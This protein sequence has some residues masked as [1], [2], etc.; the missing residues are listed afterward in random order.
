M[1]RYWVDRDQITENTVQF[2]GETFHHVIDVCRLNLGSKFEVLTE[3]GQAYFVEITEVQKK[4]AQAK[5]L[6]VRQIP[7]PPLPRIH[8]ALSLPRFQKF[9]LIVEKSVEL[10]VNSIQPL[11]SEFSFIR[12]SEKIS[13]SKKQRWE[14]I[15]RSATQQSGRGDLMTLKE[16]Q[17][18]KQWLNDQNQAANTQYL[19]MYEGEGDHSLPEVLRGFKKESLQD[20]W[21]LIGSEGGFSDQEVNL[22]REQ[23]FAPTSVGDQI[24]RVETACI[25]ITS[26]VNYELRL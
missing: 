21:I 11:F 18:L 22:L 26:M 10:G 25:A 23:G 6:E 5:I 17:S 2:L 9:E 20:V 1:R 7:Q 3:G 15:I 19:F 24:L 8:L 16:P 12:S 4:R 14:K 13:Q